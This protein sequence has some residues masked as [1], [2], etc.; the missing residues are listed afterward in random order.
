MKEDG[1]A[2]VIKHT[3]Y[4]IQ[5]RVLIRGIL[6]PRTWG[7]LSH[8]AAQPDVP[9]ARRTYDRRNGANDFP[10]DLKYRICAIAASLRI[11]CAFTASILGPFRKEQTERL[12]ILERSQRRALFQNYRGSKGD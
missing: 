1:R 12:R 3:G 9:E 2:G 7:M 4:L 5:F 6:I 10:I 11:P 8:G